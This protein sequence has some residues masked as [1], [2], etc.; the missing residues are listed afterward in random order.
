[1]DTRFSRIS[2][3]KRKV[4]ETVFSYSFGAQVK[5]FKQKNGQKSCDTV[6][7][8]FDNFQIFFKI[9]QSQ[10]NSATMLHR[11]KKSTFCTGKTVKVVQEKV[12]KSIMT[13]PERWTCKSVAEQ[14]P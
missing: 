14:S 9:Q 1:M 12:Q 2:S 3:K 8:I 4:R 10:L 7:L 6:P 11:Q 5:S 13:F